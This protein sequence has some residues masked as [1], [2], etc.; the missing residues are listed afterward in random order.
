MLKETNQLIV[1]VEPSQIQQP[2]SHKQLTTHDNQPSTSA[3]PHLPDSLGDQLTHQNT[4]SSRQP[5]I[6]N[7][8]QIS[9]LPCPDQRYNLTLSPEIP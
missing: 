6:S 7:T 3:L 2:S 8:P 1:P 4:S 9:T 5:P